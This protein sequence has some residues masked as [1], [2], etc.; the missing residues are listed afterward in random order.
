MSNE[1]QQLMPKLYL[2][3]TPE[4]QVEDLK[5]SKQTVAFLLDYSKALSVN[6]YQMMKFELLLN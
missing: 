5:P 3:D 4:E 6:D 2:N 1:K